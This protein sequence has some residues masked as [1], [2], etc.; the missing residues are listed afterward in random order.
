MKAFSDWLQ[1][2]RGVLGD[3]V[4]NLDLDSGFTQNSKGEVLKSLKLM[5]MIRTMRSYFLRVF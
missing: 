4:D 1:T 3:D 5:W 2:Q